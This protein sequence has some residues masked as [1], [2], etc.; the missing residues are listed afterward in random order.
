[1][2][3]AYTYMKNTVFIT[4]LVFNSCS[5]NVAEV[6]TDKLTLK[7]QE[8]NTQGKIQRIEEKQ[9]YTV[10]HPKTETTQ[11][12]ETIPT[13]LNLPLEVSTALVE[14]TE[15]IKKT[16][17]ALDNAKN[18]HDYSL[19]SQFLAQHVNSNGKVNYS[20]IK[21][22]ISDLNILIKDF[23]E[24]YPTQSW[25]KNEELAYWINAYNLYT[26]KLVASNYPIASIT[27]ISAKPWDSK[28]IKLGGANLSLNDI[29]HKKIR[30]R[31]NEPRIHFALNCASESCP[32]LLNT[33]FMSSSLNYQLT[34]QTKTFLEDLSKNNFSNSN[35]IVIS[36]LFD[37]YKNDFAKKEGSVVE[38]IN[39]YRSD[40]LKNP[41]IKY[42]DYSWELND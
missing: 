23:E 20:R 36:S 39:K 29:E 9:D 10:T 27:K 11:Q 26:L 37:W 38:F 12:N 5:S 15:A 24:N 40:K 28:F 22:N 8:I 14:D 7:N 19:F 35:E 25:S 1:M 33:A 21:S 2:N 42:M 13:P 34:R 17:E 6:E 30:A 18:F 16:I 3:P 41:A 4:L 31:Y 32:K